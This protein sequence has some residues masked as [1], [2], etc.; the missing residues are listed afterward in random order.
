MVTHR[1]VFGQRMGWLFSVL[2]RFRGRLLLRLLLVAAS[3]HLVVLAA[4]LSFNGLPGPLRIHPET[5]FLL[6]VVLLTTPLQAAGEEVALRGLATRAIGSWF[7]KP[8]VGLAVSA[9]VT[10]G[11]FVLLHSAS[12]LGLN[13]FYLALALSASLLTWRT[14]GLEAAIT[15]HV[16]VNLTTMLFLPFLGLDSAFD[17]DAGA[18][19]GQAWAQLIAVVLAATAILWNWASRRAS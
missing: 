12:D 7:A 19:G 15:L 2:G 9:A 16:V 8:A 10:A 4:W 11:L 13:A 5:W 14:G 18:G 17:R 6:A 1:V 3:V